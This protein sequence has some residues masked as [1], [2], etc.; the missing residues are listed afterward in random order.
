MSFFYYFL[1]LVLGMIRRG[2]FMERKKAEGREVGAMF[3]KLNAMA[4]VKDVGEKI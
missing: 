2:V 4:G 1:N 3:T